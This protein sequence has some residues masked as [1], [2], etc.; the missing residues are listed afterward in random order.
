MERTGI[1]AILRRSAFSP[2]KCEIFLC[3]N[4]QGGRGRADNEMTFSSECD[5]SADLGDLDVGSGE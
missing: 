4:G 2:V 1:G 3:E 5:D